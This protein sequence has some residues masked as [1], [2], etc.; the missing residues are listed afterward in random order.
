[1]EFLNLKPGAW[2]HS[3]SGRQFGSHDGVIG[4]MLRLAYSKDPTITEHLERLQLIHHRH[5]Q[6]P[7]FAVRCRTT[8][9]NYRSD[10]HN[11]RISSECRP[12]WQTDLRAPTSTHRTHI[13]IRDKKNISRDISPIKVPT[14]CSFVNYLFMIIDQYKLPFLQSLIA[15]P[16][17]PMKVFKLNNLH[18]KSQ[19]SLPS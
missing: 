2:W 18:K 12:K 4:L 5:L 11:R 15:G 6:R 13:Y 7:G 19:I 3:L 8:Q 9:I 1:M 10:Y 14:I 16:H 17:D